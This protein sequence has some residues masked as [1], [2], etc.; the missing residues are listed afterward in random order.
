VDHITVM[1]V[2][3]LTIP[4]TIRDTL[5]GFLDLSAVN[6]GLITIERSGS[7]K[8]TEKLTTIINAIDARHAYIRSKL[9]AEGLDIQLDPTLT[10]LSRASL[11][12]SG[13]AVQM[14]ALSEMLRWASVGQF[15][16][17]TDAI[18]EEMEATS[19][20]LVRIVGEMEKL[21]AD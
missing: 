15:S 17:L 11:A 2:V 16:S 1:N 21:L 5:E 14:E 19:D 6:A 18:E 3:N 10:S 12:Q 4:R 9:K 7:F 8:D 13:N 20:E